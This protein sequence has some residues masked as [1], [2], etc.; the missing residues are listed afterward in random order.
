MIFFILKRL[1]GV[2]PVLFII[3]SASFFIMKIAP[4]GPFDEERNVTEEVRRS[5]EAKYHLDQPLWRQ[6]TIYMSGLMKGDLGPSY[7]YEGKSV[8]E[9]IASGLKVS[10]VLGGLAMALA[11]VLGMSAGVIAGWKHNSWV[12]HLV[13]SSAMTG[14][15]IPNFVLG[16]LLVLLFSLTLRMLP[17][18]GWYGPK[19]MVL[20]VIALAMPYTAYIARLTRGGML[21]IVRMDYI[22]T[23]RAKGLTE[24]Q[25]VIRH[26]FRC[27]VLPVVSY[28]GPA[29]AGILTGILVIESIFNIPGMGRYFVLSAI[30]RD[31]TVVMGTVLVYSSMLV[32]FNLLVDITYTF[33]DPRVRLS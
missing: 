22:R 33:L 32:L 15:C 3:A 18:A 17:V 5:I 4:G 12:D 7:Q 27:A 23:A 10:V 19:Y 21:E 2:L 13:M 30:N 1:L 28:L 14:I 25:V 11:M 26:A 29:C 9:I 24:I 20:P 16:P 6:Y 31:Y 8:N